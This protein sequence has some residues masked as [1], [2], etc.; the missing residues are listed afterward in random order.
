MTLRVAR[1]Y[2]CLAVLALLG[3][4]GAAMLVAP[5][6]VLGEGIAIVLIALVGL[7]WWAM[8]RDRAWGL[9]LWVVPLGLLA[10]ASLAWGAVLPGRWW[11]GGLLLGA[12]VVAGEVLRLRALGW[13]TWR[14][15]EAWSAAAILVPAVLGAYAGVALR[16]AVERR[17][18][19]QAAEVPG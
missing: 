3:S 14:G 18:R 6:F 17:R 19:P 1:I 4:F 10:V 2:F 7:A 8:G 9:P 11:V 5:G 12:G 16:A 15:E 13:T